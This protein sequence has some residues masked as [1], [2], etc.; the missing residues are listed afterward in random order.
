MANERK[1]T[2][3]IKQALQLGYPLTVREVARF[4]D[5]AGV[6][7]STIQSNLVELEGKGK[8]CR[9]RPRNFTVELWAGTTGPAENNQRGLM[10]LAKKF[11]QATTGHDDVMVGMNFIE[12]MECGKH[13]HINPSSLEYP[14]TQHDS[15]RFSFKGLRPQDF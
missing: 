10:F 5:M 2:E 12:C 8:A 14:L 11:H 9:Y 13:A 7:Y 15:E 4:V 3:R 6:A 1:Y